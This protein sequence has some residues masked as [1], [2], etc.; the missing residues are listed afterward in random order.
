MALLSCS[1]R[2]L[3]TPYSTISVRAI[4]CSSGKIVNPGGCLASFL[5]WSRTQSEG[6]YDF[7]SLSSES[8]AFA[9]GQSQRQF[10][11]ISP[12]FKV[13]ETLRVQADKSHLKGLEQESSSDPVVFGDESQLGGREDSSRLLYNCA[14]FTPGI[15]S[16]LPLP[17][18]TMHDL[19]ACVVTIGG[20]LGMLRF[21]DELAKRDVLEKKLSR[22]LVHILVGLGFMLFWPL[23]SLAPY[24]K[25]LCALAPAGNGVRMLGLGFGILKNEAMVKAMSREG[26]RREL[27]KGPFYYAL[28]IVVT[29]VCFWRSSPVGI[30]ALVNLCAGDGF[31]D[32]IGRNFG[33]IKLP[34]NRDKSFAGS[35]GMFV[36]STSVSMLYL[37]YFAHFGYIEMVPGT[38]ARVVIVSFLTTV[39]E[40]LP[41]S[42]RLDDNLTVPFAAMALGMLIFPS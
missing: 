34:Y 31:A 8:R 32:I 3:S 26:G 11:R 37:M 10:Q 4:S 35:I 6:K 5:D 39:V 14:I 22:K 38:F 21:F 12:I 25:Y 19:I 16:A 40:S 24:A 20:A 18:V 7:D 17:T 15:A 23:F 30:V 29:T 33:G 1:S 42:T 13:F 41:F 2:S 9:H 36:A 28:A 27:L